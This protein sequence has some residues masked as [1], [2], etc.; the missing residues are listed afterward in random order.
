MSKAKAVKVEG[1]KAVLVTTD[2]DRRGVFFGYVPDDFDIKAA[3]EGMTITL[4]DARMVVYWSRETKGVLGL[5][6]IGPQVGSRV[7][8]KLP[9]WTINGVTGIGEVT[10]EA[11]KRFEEGLWS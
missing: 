8:P 2:K 11:T 10:E 3:V 6:S 4:E 1:R 5:A 7:T 9:S